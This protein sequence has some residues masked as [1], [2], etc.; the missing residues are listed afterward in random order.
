MNDVLSFYQEQ[1]EH[2]RSLHPE[3]ATLQAQALD[4]FV[5]AGFPTRRDEA[6]KY[7]A[8]DLF[9]KERFHVNDNK[10]QSDTRATVTSEVDTS[11]WG[12]KLSVING[13]IQNLDKL[14]LPSGVF[15]GAFDQALVQK[16]GLLESY[17]PRLGKSEHGFHALNT[18]MLQTNL[19]IYV[20]KGVQVMSPL[21]LAHFQSQKNQAV[22]LQYVV[23][24]EEGASLT[25]IED[26]DGVA[27]C[28]YMTSSLTDLFLAERA[29]LTH[30]VIQRE[31]RAAFHVSHAFG[32]LEAASQLNSHSVHLGGK[33]VRSD[34]SFYL[35]GKGAGCLLNGL[36]GL[37]NQQ[38]L[39][40]HTLVRHEVGE[41][42]SIQ[43]YK[44]VV[45]GPARA[46]FNGGIVVEKDA[47]HSRAQQQNKNLLLS[48]DAEVDTKPQLE[49]FANDVVC[50]HG[51][52]VGQ[53]SEEALFYF[54]SRGIDRVEAI[55]FLVD[56]FTAT[57]LAMIEDVNLRTWLSG[58][59]HTHLQ[60]AERGEK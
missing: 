42:E 4:R 60:G 38:H 33:W 58:L 9:L 31:S 46:V 20:P 25:L 7:S 45:S 41:C 22:F 11:F 37:A 59:L 49:I 5:K 6:W 32:H 21:T 44:G 19:L 2:L 16:Q 14:A 8:P 43:D 34:K 30:I 51:A 18:A 10:E 57:N 1:A 50:S 40:Q 15:I 26:Y 12:Q 24:L 27:T 35:Q 48:R 56:A 17:L 13:T 39:D 52:T 23:I 36:Y 53:L 3:L 29:Q 55:Q 54:L 28:P 47:Q